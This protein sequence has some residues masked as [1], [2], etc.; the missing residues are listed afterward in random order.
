MRGHAKEN[1]V[2]DATRLLTTAELARYLGRAASS[3][4]KDRVSGRLGLPF[5]RLGRLVRYRPEDVEAWVAARRVHS[6]SEG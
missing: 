2:L 6:T 5:V 3:L 4:E 1:H